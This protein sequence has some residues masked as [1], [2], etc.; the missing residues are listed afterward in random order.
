MFFSSYT[1]DVVA[2]LKINGN[3]CLSKLMFYTS[4]ILSY[5]YFLFK[6]W[7]SWCS[8]Q[9][10][11]HEL[12]MFLTPSL[13]SFW[14]NHSF[15]KTNLHPCITFIVFLRFVQLTFIYPI[16]LTFKLKC[17]FNALLFLLYTHFCL[18]PF[19]KNSHLYK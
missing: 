14:M 9:G 11:I 6:G 16:K 4:T 10:N 17:S 7:C 15:W 19:L 2:F 1:F 3:M 5:E 13:H 18:V 12:H 8:L